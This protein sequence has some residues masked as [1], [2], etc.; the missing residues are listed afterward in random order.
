M[1]L[2]FLTFFLT[3]G[4]V[5][6]YV[7]LK[8]RT[9][10]GLGLGI[11][12]GLALFLATMVLAPVVVRLL[13]RHGLLLAARIFAYFGY[14][15]MGLLFFFFWMS[16]CLDFYNLCIRLLSLISS[17]ST[18]RL[19]WTGKSAFA[20]LV[21]ATIALGLYSMIEAWHIRLQ[22]LSL[23]TTKLPAQ[24]KQLTIVQISD[25]HL[26][27]MVGERRL[28][29]ML[30]LIKKAEPD[31]LVCTGDLVDAQMDH[32]NH[33]ADMLAEIHP[34]LGK[35]AV[36]GNHEFYAGIKQSQL[37]L[38]MAGFTLLRGESR[39][40]GGL[41]TLVGVDDPAASY[42]QLDNGIPAKEESLLLSGLD[43]KILTLLLKHRPEVEQ[44]SLGHFD[45]QLSG[46]THKGQI[47]PFSLV[48]RVYYPMQDGLYR[49]DK[50][51]LLYVSRGTGTWGPPMRF[52][53]P[54][55]VTVIKVTRIASGDGGS[56][57]S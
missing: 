6:L 21:F 23:R 45:L 37:F 16:L 11:S 15:W 22:R 57:R 17:S 14:T 10:L 36:T 44:A 56:S 25:L 51:S 9:A 40:V 54:P 20:F 42:R 39:N 26:G 28:R 46:H 3:Y 35:F 49:L 8:A 24:V 31:L 47:F 19:L 1:S 13:D 33:L 7:F 18:A 52:L 48:T 2:F 12:I 29:P 53:S 30:D 34:P 32:L 4:A 27:L 50:G 43:Q 5:H 38:T 55:Q 41:L